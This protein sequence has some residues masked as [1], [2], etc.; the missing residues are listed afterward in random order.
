MDGKRVACE[1]DGEAGAGGGAAASSSSFGGDGAEPLHVRNVYVG[2]VPLDVKEEEL[3]AVFE[4]FGALGCFGTGWMDGWMGLL[5]YR[6][7]CPLS[8]PQT[9][10]IDLI[11]LMG[12]GAK[13]QDIAFV[14]Y[15]ERESARRAVEALGGSRP[16]IRGQSLDVAMAKPPRERLDD[17]RGG[18]GGY[19]G[20]GY[21]DRDRDQRD[22]SYRREGYYRGGGGSSYG[23]GGGGACLRMCLFWLTDMT[24]HRRPTHPPTC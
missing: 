5:A 22:F 17:R 24:H 3:R 8:V 23:G 7:L 19:G 9:G 12:P 10:E 4:P 1:W 14:N 6:T 16:Q 11:K 21:G 18:Y 2:S 13:R 15:K 20:G